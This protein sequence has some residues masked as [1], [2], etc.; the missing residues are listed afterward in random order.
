[1]FKAIFDKENFKAFIKELLILAGVVIVC[2][3]T[4]LAIYVFT[5]FAFLFIV[6]LIIAVIYLLPKVES[7][8][9]KFL[10]M[11]ILIYF[12][13]TI[14]WPYYIGV[15]TGF[16]DLHPSRVL[17]FVI[18]IVGLYFFLKSIAFRQQLT[19]YRQ[20]SKYFI[21]VIVLYLV[22]HISGIGFSPH[23]AASFS[24]VFKFLF[25][26]YIPAILFLMLI[27]RRQILE[28]IINTII[29]L[30]AV[31]AIVGVWESL[32]RTPFWP[33]F[34][35]FLVLNDAISEFGIWRRDIYRVTSTF[36]HPLSMVHFQVISLSLMG[37]RF[38]KTKSL[39]IKLLL[40]SVVSATIFVM[41]ESDSR[42]VMPALFVMIGIL[43]TSYAYAGMRSKNMSFIGWLFVISFP[44]IAIGSVMFFYAGR[45]V[46]MGASDIATLST[47]ARYEMWDLAWS[48]IIAN[49]IAGLL[50]FG[51]QSST[52]VVNWHGG[53]SI[54]S[55]LI[56]VL[57]DQGIIGLTLFIWI[58]FYTTILA[59]KIWFRSK[60]TDFLPIFIVIAL[61]GYMI[62][63]F[64]SSLTH[65][66]HI[67]YIFIAMIWILSR[68]N[69]KE[70][71]ND[72]S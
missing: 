35:P 4:V 2:L 49:P 39:M 6:P 30:G 28:D 48:R 52:T 11:A 41:F 45:S 8:P 59:I 60:L 10:R 58:Y 53:V 43:L 69:Y 21:I 5:P 20:V 31:V 18:V 3:Y 62:I 17:L 13:L 51:L 22:T 55:F 34:F 26:V 12:P 65:L 63:A 24:G 38:F 47:N 68:I 29:F 46:F 67:Y 40:I 19:Q 27:N 25:E 72:Y 42:S 14:I 66:L 50:G 70:G 36:S 7:Y 1:M 33:N 9:E 32:S 15:N 37:Y 56:S 16:M 61:S 57:I 71:L 54:D 64:I 23:A 44:I